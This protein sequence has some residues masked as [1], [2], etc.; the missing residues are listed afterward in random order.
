[1][2]GRTALHCW[3]VITAVRGCIPFIKWEEMAKEG[4]FKKVYQTWVMT[5]FI[6]NKKSVGKVVNG[7]LRGPF[8]MMEP[9]VLTQSISLL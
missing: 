1:M 3:S 4:G 6:A 2:L 5:P 9:V 8:M 7:P